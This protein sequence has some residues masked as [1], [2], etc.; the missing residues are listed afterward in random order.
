MS[1]RSLPSLPSRSSDDTQR[2]VQ[3]SRSASRLLLNL[4]RRVNDENESRE[5]PRLQDVSVQ[6]QDH[7]SEADIALED[8]G[9]SRARNR[10]LLKEMLGNFRAS[11]KIAL[12]DIRC[13]SELAVILQIDIFTW[14]F[15]PMMP[16]DMD[17]EESEETY[18]RLASY[19]I[20]YVRSLHFHQIPIEQYVH[21]FLSWLFLAGNQG[22]T[23]LQ[24]LQ[25]HVL[26]DS[27][28]LAK[29]L[30][31][32]SFELPALEQQGMDMLLRL[33]SIVQVLELLLRKGQLVTSL[34]ILKQ[35]PHLLNLG[36]SSS[37]SMKDTGSLVDPC[38]LL[39]CAMQLSS[40]RF[41]EGGPFFTLHSFFLSVAPRLV[42]INNTVEERSPLGNEA[43]RRGLDPRSVL[44]DGEEKQA[45]KEAFGL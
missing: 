6:D 25:Y 14:V 10:P 38:D 21:E 32:S 40:R 3:R 19:L 35:H 12:K 2:Q 24:L 29:T 26:S 9:N 20:L 23:L 34:K 16:E 43:F 30:I 28:R 36:M 22:Q 41:G 15:M 45:V 5:S 44:V 33:N 13:S 39:R 7:V 37:T 17:L 27:K 11:G 4:R 42:T 31:E 8:A 1:R 18:K